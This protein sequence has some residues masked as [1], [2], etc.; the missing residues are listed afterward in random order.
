MRR[1]YVSVEITA[2]KDLQIGCPFRPLF[3]EHLARNL[4]RLRGTNTAADLPWR[5]IVT[6]APLMAW[7]KDWTGLPWRLSG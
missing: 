2:G 5:V 7:Q 3:L 1:T 6:S 4:G